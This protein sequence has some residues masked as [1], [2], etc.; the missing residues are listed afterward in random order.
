MFICPI[1]NLTGIH[2]LEIQIQLFKTTMLESFHGSCT[3]LDSSN[4]YNKQIVTQKKHNTV[5]CLSI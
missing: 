1:K 3:K 2:A 5:N 4:I